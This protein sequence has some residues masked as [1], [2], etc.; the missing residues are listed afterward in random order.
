MSTCESTII[1]EKSLLPCQMTTAI[2]GCMHRQVIK[3]RAAYKFG[4]R[5]RSICIL[6]VLIF[7]SRKHVGPRLSRPE[8]RC[9]EPSG[10]TLIYWPLAVAH[11]IFSKFNAVNKIVKHHPGP[12]CSACN[13]CRRIMNSLSTFFHAT[14]GIFYDHHKF[15]SGPKYFSLCGWVRRWT[16]VWGLL[17]RPSGGDVMPEGRLD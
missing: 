16:G 10:K 7:G 11:F 12:K 13:V 17:L 15:G 9:R 2:K 6:A 3:S 5:C 1:G 8:K 14:P 4:A